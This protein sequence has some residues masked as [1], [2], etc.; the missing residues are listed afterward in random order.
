MLADEAKDSVVQEEVSGPALVGEVEL[1]EKG[2]IEVESKW[3]DELEYVADWNVVNEAVDGPA[4]VEMTGQIVS[5]DTDV[6]THE[7]H[8]T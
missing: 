2:A 4:L 6:I 8:S 5:S 3:S 7:I 1:L